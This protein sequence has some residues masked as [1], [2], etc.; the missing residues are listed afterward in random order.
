MIALDRIFKAYD[1]RGTVPDQLDERTCR[2]IGWAFARFCGTPQVL[3]GRDM[4]S[5]GE[6]LSEAFATGAR[7]AGADVIEL[8]L[9]STD[10]MYFAS[11]RLDAPGAM[12]TASHNPAGYNGIKM[13]LA[14][15]RPIGQDTGLADI[16][17]GAQ[18]ALD[19]DVDGG[20]P[21]GAISR[22]DMLEDYATHVRSFVDVR[23]LRPLRI[24]AD[25]ANGMGGLVAPKVFET[26]P[27]HVDVLFPELDGTF[28]N[29][30]ADPIQEENLID[31]KAAV[32]EH[33]ADVGL[34]FDGD[35]DRVFLV[36][37]KAQSVS[38]SLTTALVAAAMLDKN[39]GSTVL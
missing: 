5:S 16:Q 6:A 15:A 11:G 27:F 34:A 1:V 13:C 10:L 18:E 4:R 2:A 37:E 31:L 3:V 12:F 20:A 14:G 7:T 28:P 17:R 22:R 26:L 33:N 8:G 29:H 25:T 32:L 19:T 35:A 38:G 39:P 9:V 21:Q 23:S 24:V 36:D 30:P